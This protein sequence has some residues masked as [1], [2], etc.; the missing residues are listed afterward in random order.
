MHYGVKGM[1]WGQHLFGKDYTIGG[2]SFPKGRVR[3]DNKKAFQY[4]RKATITGRAK[5]IA[6][7]KKEKAKNRMLNNPYSDRLKN[8]YKEASKVAAN[9]DREY[10]ADHNRAKQH[11]KKLRSRY[12]RENV[13]DL[14]YKK[15]GNR[16]V[17]NEPIHSKSELASRAAFNALS[18]GLMATGAVPI[19]VFTWS[20][21]KG[22]HGRGMYISERTRVRRENRR[23]HAN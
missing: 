3:A 18:A 21:S 12:G 13:K 6:D 2:K 11:V 17:V 9:L 8:K 7:R 4:G 23:S 15:F 1:R 10:E 5:V 19:S 22:T 16:Y 14:V 20:N